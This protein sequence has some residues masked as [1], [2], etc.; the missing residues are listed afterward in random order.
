MLLDL[1]RWMGKVFL[2]VL[3]LVLW[4]GMSCISSEQCKF[5][6]GIGTNGV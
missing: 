4:L 2:N 1:K 6:V 3:R 5:Q